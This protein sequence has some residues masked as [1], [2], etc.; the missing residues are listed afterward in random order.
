MT[1]EYVLNGLS[2]SG[3]VGNVKQALLEVPN[4]QY[5]DVLL[6]PQTAFITMS[7]SININQLQSQLSQSGN[8]TI[9]EIGLQNFT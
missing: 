3:C 9:D 8:Y 2:Y 6:Y 5:V 1:K 7:K 4:V